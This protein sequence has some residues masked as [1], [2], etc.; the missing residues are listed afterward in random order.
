VVGDD[1]IVMVDTELAPLHDK[2]KAA[3]AENS[4]LRRAT[5][6]IQ[7]TSSAWPTIRSTGRK[8]YSAG[9]GGG[10]VPCAVARA[11]ARTASQRH[12]T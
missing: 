8:C 1:G 7:S 11:P 10:S 9:A 4:N 2:I 3:I 5:S 12:T 6:G